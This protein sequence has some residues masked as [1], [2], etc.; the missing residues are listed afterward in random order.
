M[1][2]ISTKSRKYQ[3][4]FNNPEEHN[5]SHSSINEIMKQLKWEYYCLCDEV[6]ENQTPH[7]H[8]FFY[9]KNAVSFD[10]LKKLFPTAHIES[11]LGSCQENRD[12]IRKEGKYLN[13]D[14]K[15]TN[16]IDTFEEYGEMPLDKSVKNE[17]QSEE[18]VQMLKDGYSNKEIIDVFPSAY[19]QTKQMD[20]YRKTLLKEKGKSKC[21]EKAVFYIWGETGT[22]KTTFVM[23]K[24]GFEN[25]YTVTDYK[26]PFD[27]YNGEKVIL[28]DEF[29]SSLPINS[30]LHYL[31]KFPCKLPARYENTFAIYDTVYIISNISLDEQYKYEDRETFNAFLRRIKEVTVFDKREFSF[32]YDPNN[33]VQTSFSPIDFIR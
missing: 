28:F 6:G 17:N 22:G 4:T 27:D 7:I 16:M 9:C 24:Y 19:R 31:Q 10:R 1:F 26:N 11:A 29:H 8:L 30:M 5:V 13:S 15:E 25:V 23:E 3:L 32:E 2:I 21:I 33:I 12:Y 14:K 18:I 20:A